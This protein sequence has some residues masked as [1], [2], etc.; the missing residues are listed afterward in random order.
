LRFAVPAT[1]VKSVNGSVYV[2]INDVGACRVSV[3]KGDGDG[4]RSLV[5]RPSVHVIVGLA[6]GLAGLVRRGP[7]PRLGQRG[8]ARPQ[9]QGWQLVLAR[10]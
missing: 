1:G 4:G 9:G 7:V 10:G 5:A 6:R 2:T 3:F 8:Q